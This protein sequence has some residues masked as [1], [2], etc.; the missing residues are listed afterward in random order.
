[1]D[2]ELVPHPVPLADAVQGDPGAGRVGDVV[3]PAVQ[4][5]PARH[6]AL[7]HPVGEAARLGLAHERNELLLEHLEVGVHLKIGVAS[8]EAAD[9]VGLQQH[10]GIEHPQHELVLGAP[11]PVVGDQQV[12]EVGE[13]GKPDA[14]G[15]HGGPD[16]GRA[17]LIEG[18]PQIQRVGHRI[19]HGFGGHIGA[20][21][22]QRRRKLD[23]GGADLPRELKPFLDGQV[24]VRIP[25]FA[26]RQLLE[27]SG[28][29]AD[30][31]GLGIK[32][33]DGM[34]HESSA[35]GA[36]QVRGMVVD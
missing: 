17:G 29:D 12:V 4:R 9:R 24:R 2:A 28:Q 19:E 33:G 6:R 36:E 3:V 32:W 7:L 30:L 35:F 10:G 5:R 31:H 20:G 23:V 1:M 21:R 8:D 22:V 14:D 25:R 15:L 13:V 18:R 27:R 26:R 11:R 34:T 16:T